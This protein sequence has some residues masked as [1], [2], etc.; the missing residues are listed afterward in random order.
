MELI[1]C[2]GL[3]DSWTSTI[4]WLTPYLGKVL[5]IMLFQK[6]LILAVSVLCPSFFRRIQPL[7]IY[8]HSDFQFSILCGVVGFVC[9]CAC[10]CVFCFVFVVCSFVS[11]GWLS[12]YLLIQAQD[13]LIVH[14]SSINS[15]W[16]SYQSLYKMGMTLSHIWVAASKS[17]AWQPSAFSLWTITLHI[18]TESCM[19]KKD[20]WPPKRRDRYLIVCVVITSALSLQISSQR[21]QQM[22]ESLPRL[23]GRVA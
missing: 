13:F 12:V 7:L 14:W 3:L 22:L 2:M 18:L 11:E 20:K 17:S 19:I 5:V 15:T 4:A 16:P 21:L 10:V 1:S 9:F 23:Q 6:L 8:R